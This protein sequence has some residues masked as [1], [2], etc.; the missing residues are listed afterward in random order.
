MQDNQVYLQNSR[1]FINKYQI[2]LKILNQA[3]HNTKH[4]K[5][6]FNIL[7]KL[8]QIIYFLIKNL[9]FLFNFAFLLYYLSLLLLIYSYLY[10]FQKTPES[11]LLI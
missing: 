4:S 1:R 8:T 3:L 6:Y 2:F 7:F 9:Y 10:Y 5:F 11:F